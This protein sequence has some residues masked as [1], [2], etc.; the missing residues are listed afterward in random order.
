MTSKKHWITTILRS[1]NFFLT[2]LHLSIHF[3]LFLTSVGKLNKLDVCF[4]PVRYVQPVANNTP[5]P[6][7]VTLNADVSWSW[8]T[9]VRANETYRPYCKYIKRLNLCMTYLSNEFVKMT[10]LLKVNCIHCSKTYHFLYH[11]FKQ[12]M[13]YFTVPI[14][15]HFSE[16]YI[17]LT[18]RIALR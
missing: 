18:K 2:Y 15:E 4:P 6:T 17:K 13:T 7:N 5:L 9:K 1:F 3:F 11:I 10:I 16:I 12:L 8:K 14:L